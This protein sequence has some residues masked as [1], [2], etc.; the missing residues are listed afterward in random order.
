MLSIYGFP[1]FVL[2]NEHLARNKTKSLSSLKHICFNEKKHICFNEK[3]EKRPINRSKYLRSKYKE[4]K[5]DK[6]KR[7]DGKMGLFLSE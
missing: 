3:S 6:T 7:G 1:G 2:R 4:E 5:D